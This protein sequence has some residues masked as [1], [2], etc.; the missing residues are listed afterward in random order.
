M[1]MTKLLSLI[2][3]VLL[4]CSVKK[5]VQKESPSC[6]TKVFV[7]DYSSLDGCGFMFI[8]PDGT[9]ILPSNPELAEFKLRDRQMVM[10]G[11]ISQKDMMSICMSENFI[12]ELLCIELISEPGVE[13]QE[14]ANCIPINDPYRSVWMKELMISERPRE[15][16]RMKYKEKLI[17]TL[18]TDRGVSV[19]NCLGDVLCQAGNEHRDDCDTFWKGASDHNVIWVLN[20]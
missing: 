17:Y 13:M 5:N 20:E 6:D 4:S 12:A 8:L 15:V 14:D 19:Y 9:K 18:R 3:C 7:R 10:I 1:D 16:S 11:Y 2:T